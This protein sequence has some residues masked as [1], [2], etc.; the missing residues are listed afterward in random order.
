MNWKCFFLGHQRVYNE[1]EQDDFDKTM[2]YIHVSCAR[3]KADLGYD[4]MGFCDAA[5]KN[6]EDQA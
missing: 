1:D 4:L 6:H 3:C 2:C 5:I